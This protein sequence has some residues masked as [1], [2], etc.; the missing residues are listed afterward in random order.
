MK[1]QNG[2]FGYALGVLAIVTFAKGNPAFAGL[3]SQMNFNAGVFASY[4]P[5][6]TQGNEATQSVAITSVPI[7]QT[8]TADD[9]NGGAVTATYVVTDNGS[10]AT[11]NINCA[12][13]LTAPS[14]D[15]IEGYD[16]PATGYQGI[17][18]SFSQPVEY[19]AVLTDTGGAQESCQFGVGL[20]EEI[21]AEFFDKTLYY[22]GT[23]PA[24]EGVGLADDWN[25]FNNGLGS[26][27]T[28]RTGS[29]SLSFTF[30]AVPEPSSV[31]MIGIPAVFALCRRRRHR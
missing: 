13:T 21:N 23:I 8:I 22:S 3:F 24:G 2:R 6:T 7:D 10:V 9:L 25:M 12:G 30:T 16:L 11:I 18:F 27:Y 19:S 28:N 1:M 14:N 4:T 15:L 17:G 5:S 29:E 26:Q 20:A 31:V